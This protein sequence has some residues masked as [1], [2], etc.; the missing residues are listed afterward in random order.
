MV[1]VIIIILDVQ[2]SQEGGGRSKEHNQL[3][4]I[5][6]RFDIHN[7]QGHCDGVSRIQSHLENI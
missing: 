5:G 2:H 3:R 6:P 7:K 1:N 4:G